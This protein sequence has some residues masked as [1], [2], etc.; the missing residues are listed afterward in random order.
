MDY[1]TV[2][3]DAFGRSLTGFGVNLLTTDVRGLAAF[4]TEVFELEAFQVSD[5]FAIVQNGDAV[6]QLHSDR[7][8]GN[9]PLLAYVPENPPRGGGFQLY[10]FNID[11]DKAESRANG[12]GFTVIETSAD[13]PHGLREC[14]ILS[15]EGYA[16]SPA[17]PK[18]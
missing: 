16:F 7:T 2:D 12:L 9:H 14:T 17:A 15:P 6:M 8:Y 11:P 1:E 18:G 10:L 3:A 4:L 13:K 5:D